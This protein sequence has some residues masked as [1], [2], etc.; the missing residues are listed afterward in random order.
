MTHSIIAH[1][2]RSGFLRRTYHLCTNAIWMVPVFATLAALVLASI[3]SRVDYTTPFSLG[4]LFTTGGAQGARDL[5]QT[6]AS[7]SLTVSTFVLSVTIV[8]LQIA[9]SQYSPRL[10]GQLLRDKSTQFVMGT[11]IFTFVY[12]LAIVRSIQAVDSFVPQFA[13]TVSFVLVICSVLAFIYYVHHIVQSIRIETILRYVVDG[14][15][16]AGELTYSAIDDNGN[17]KNGNGQYREGRSG[18]PRE[19]VEIPR[20]ALPIMSRLSGVIQR[21]EGAPLRDYATRKDIVICLTKMLGGHVTAG[22]PLG[23]YWPDSEG[24]PTPK[25][26]DVVEQVFNVLDV[27]HER[28]LSNDVAF[29]LTQLVDIALRAV[30]PAIND[31][32]TGC[33]ALQSAETVLVTLCALDL[34]DEELC[35]ASGTVRVVVPKHS[36]EALLDQ[37]VTPVRHASPDDMT[38]VLRLC[39]MLANLA[40]VAANDAQRAVLSDQTE[41]LMR[42]TNDVFDE[43]VDRFKIERAVGEVRAALAHEPPRVRA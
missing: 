43:E 40:R 7:T 3:A 41:R 12:S 6:V 8:V 37:V 4:G 10:P 19:P 21:V 2:H 14:A 24:D 13:V 30:S 28:D 33:N 16:E 22:T 39:E 5:V 15:I 34:R 9:G 42:A 35:D 36:F 38:I 26:C 11:F 23:W 25:A 29:G 20:D 31:P 32:T 18:E 27:G 17:S 1:P